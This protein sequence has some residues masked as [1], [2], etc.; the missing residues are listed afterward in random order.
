MA[1]SD[2][3]FT[4]CDAARLLNRFGPGGFSEDVR[5]LFEDYFA[6]RSE[7]DLSDSDSGDDTEQAAAG[8]SQIHFCEL[9]YDS[10]CILVVV[11]PPFSRH[12]ISAN[13]FH[14][15]QNSLMKFRY[16]LLAWLSL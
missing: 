4:P 10:G 11:C 5:Q 9:L 15:T 3:S 12:V 7:D 13:I 6:A 16:S 2:R 1:A 14:V 8:S